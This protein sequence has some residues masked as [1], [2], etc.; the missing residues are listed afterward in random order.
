MNRRVII[1]AL[2]IIATGLC[3]IPSLL[4]CL[5][6]LWSHFIEDRVHARLWSSQLIVIASHQGRIAAVPFQ[7]DGDEW[8]S[9]TSGEVDP[10]SAFPLSKPGKSDSWHGF[11]WLID[12]DYEFVG[13]RKS[14]EAGQL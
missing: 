14:R 6:W 13:T 9:H 4:I 7:W 10:Q 2:R 8:I 3:L 1:T 12:P 11:A 5:V